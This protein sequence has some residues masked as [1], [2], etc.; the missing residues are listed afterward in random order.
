M[1]RADVGTA[2]CGDCVT[3]MEQLADRGGEDAATAA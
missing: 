2:F 1:L 3:A